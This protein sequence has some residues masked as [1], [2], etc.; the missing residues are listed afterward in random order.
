LNFLNRLSQGEDPVDFLARS[1]QTMPT[2][3]APPFV[4]KKRLLAERVRNWCCGRTAGQRG[5]F[6]TFQLIE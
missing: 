3:M 6:A 2:T 1:K 4:L 5:E